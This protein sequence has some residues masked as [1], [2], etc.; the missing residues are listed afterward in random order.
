MK[1]NLYINKFLH[2]FEVMK[3]RTQDKVVYLTFDDGP[4]PDI[5]EFVLKQLRKYR[6]TAT[7]FCMGCKAREYPDL[8][9]AILNDGHSIGNHTYNHFH[10]FHTLTHDYIVDVKMADQILRTHLFRPPWGA[11]SLSVFLKLR[12]DYKIVY[13]SLDSG[14]SGNESFQYE[15]SKQRLIDRTTVGSVV[16]FH[17]CHKH[18]NETKRLLPMYLNWLE[19]NG[20]KSIKMD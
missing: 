4:D 18:A 12:K 13:W 11:L 15:R 2:L 3:I 20:Y 5:T 8:L 10:S 6:F 19:R 1:L 17:C 14:D 9:Y 7:F 16:L